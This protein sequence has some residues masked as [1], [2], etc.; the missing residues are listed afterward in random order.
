MSYCD[1]CKERIH[2][3]HAGKQ[4]DKK[5]MHQWCYII[6]I[7][8]INNIWDTWV[9]EIKEQKELEANQSG[10]IGPALY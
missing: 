4:L 5:F 2:E 3:L 9:A 7:E 10:P 8:K 1:F 6:V